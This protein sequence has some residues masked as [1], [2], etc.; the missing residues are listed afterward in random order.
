MLI[1]ILFKLFLEVEIKKYMRKL[2]KKISSEILCFF[3]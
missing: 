3:D 1:F 2:E